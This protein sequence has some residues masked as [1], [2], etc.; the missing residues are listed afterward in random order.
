MHCHFFFF[1]HF[2]NVL[3]LPSLLHGFWWEICSISNCSFSVGNTFSPPVLNFFPLFLIFRHLIMMY[4]GV[5]L[6]EFIQVFEFLSL[7][8]YLSLF[9]FWVYSGIWIGRFMSFA[10]F[11]KFSAIISSNIFCVLYSLSSSWDSSDRSVLDLL[12]LYLRYLRFSLLF[13]FFYL[14]WIISTDTSLDSLILSSGKSLF[15]SWVHTVHFL[16]YCN[17]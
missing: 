3:L 2:K 5:D 13:C 9:L 17:V 6:F 8:S 11:E 12:L 14:L 1:W 10:K 7:F 4:L 16:T 15:C